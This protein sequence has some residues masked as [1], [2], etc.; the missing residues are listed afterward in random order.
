MNEN[1]TNAQEQ[2]ELGE[3]Y[4]VGDGIFKDLQDALKWYTK[5]AEQGHADALYR[6]SLV[7]LSRRPENIFL[8]HGYNITQYSEYGWGVEKNPAQARRLLEKAIERGS[9]KAMWQ[10]A[11]V[12][13]MED[14]YG[15]NYETDIKLSAY[16]YEKAAELGEKDSQHTTGKNYYFGSGVPKDREK[17]KYWI[18]LAAKQGYKI[19]QEDLAKIEAGK[20]LSRCYIATCVYGSYDCPEVW[21]L[22]RYRDNS[23]SASWFGRQFIRIYYTVSP[24]LVELFGD[25]KWFSSLWKPVLNKLVC[26]LQENGVEGSPYSDL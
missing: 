1:P 4:E 13:I 6:L 26:K 20:S 17:A 23:L 21:T 3:K 19:A 12:L 7:Y 24:K 9:A 16:W 8:T 15:Y 18:E 2:F 5:A 25:K 11:K 14:K 22:R 10:F